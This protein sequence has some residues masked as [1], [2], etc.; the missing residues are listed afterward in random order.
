MKVLRMTNDLIPEPAEKPEQAAATA[1]GGVQGAGSSS[2]AEDD[3]A[4]NELAGLYQVQPMQFAAWRGRVALKVP[5]KCI[6][7][8]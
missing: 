5:S 7:R 2:S 4:V 6:T 1:W 3:K 8:W